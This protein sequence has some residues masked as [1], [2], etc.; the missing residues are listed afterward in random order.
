[1]NAKRASTLFLIAFMPI[2]ASCAMRRSTDLSLLDLPAG[3]ELTLHPISMEFLRVVGEYDRIDGYADGVEQRLGDTEELKKYVVF[4]RRH[5]S[6]GNVLLEILAPHVKPGD[7]LYW[8][9]LNK[10]VERHSES[11]VLVVRNNEIV[12]KHIEHSLTVTT[13]VESIISE[14]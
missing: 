5:E 6:S 2:L 4:M 1:M 13:D 3:T 9:D 11:G 12:F 8:F 7:L 14:K 10:D